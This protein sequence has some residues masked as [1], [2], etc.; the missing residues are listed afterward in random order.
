MPSFAWNGNDYKLHLF[1]L[2]L[3]C[4]R[5]ESCSLLFQFVICFLNHGFCLSYKIKRTWEALNYRIRNLGNLLN[6]PTF[7][8]ISMWS[9]FSQNVLA[10]CRPGI[11]LLLNGCLFYK[12]DKVQ[13][14]KKD[15]RLKPSM[16][17]GNSLESS[18]CWS[19][20]TFHAIKLRGGRERERN[21]TEVKG[22]KNRVTAMWI[23]RSSTQQFSSHYEKSI[24]CWAEMKARSQPTFLC[25][26]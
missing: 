24:L 17:T 8:N 1:P 10:P 13:A 26:T 20:I 22:I 11:W 16:N 7:T 5:N 9:T 3:L 25:L 4:E 15:G 18:Y 6:F 14:M 19:P 2:F 23:W 12:K 21:V